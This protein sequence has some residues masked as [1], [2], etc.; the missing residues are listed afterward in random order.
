MHDSAKLGL[1]FCHISP[2]FAIAL[3][4]ACHDLLATWMSVLHGSVVSTNK[5][6]RR[7]FAQ[8]KA[9][10]LSPCTK[11]ELAKL[12]AGSV[13]HELASMTD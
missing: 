10:V 3:A 11:T 5:N 1:S 9:P 6:S 12:S 2:D 7:I 8:K 13:R 4:A